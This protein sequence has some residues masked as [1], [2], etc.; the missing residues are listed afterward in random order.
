MEDENK[1]V[2]PVEEVNAEVVEDV[3]DDFADTKANA[4]AKAREEKKKEEEAAKQEEEEAAEEADNLPDPYPEQASYEYGDLKLNDIEQARLSFYKQYKKLNATKVAIS[5][6][7]LVL[8]VL[9]WILPNVLK[10]GGDNSMIPMMISLGVA[11]VVL[12]G[13]GV[14]SFISRKQNDKNIKSYFGVLYDN[15]NQYLFSGLPVEAIQGNVDCKVSKEEFAANGMYPGVISIGSRDNIT[16]T[17]NKMDCALADCAAQKDAG[18]AMATVFVGKYLRT[19]NSFEGSS[20]GLVIYFRGNKRALPPE[21]LPK[22]NQLEKNK[23]YA[24]YG[25]PAD[26]KFISPKIRSLLKEIHTNKVLVDVA[27]AIKPGKTYFALGYEDSLMVLPMQKP[28]NPG[29][30]QEYKEELKLFLE[31]AY[32]FYD[33]GGHKEEAEAS[34][35]EETVNE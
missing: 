32:A 11:A 8:I 33:K 28:F 24:I 12:I 30:T 27:I 7:G 26:K 34:E 10:W 19:A 13:L 1:E 9:F 16:F 5:V 31:L 21:S 20:D 2:V 6:V 14:M 17:Y 22:L 4:E 18:K 3:D 25:N 23:S 15:L 29:P 35:A